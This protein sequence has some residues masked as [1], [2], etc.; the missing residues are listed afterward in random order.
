[1]LVDEIGLSEYIEDDHLVS[2]VNMAI[3]II[4]SKMFPD[5][6]SDFFQLSMAGPVATHV[7]S[8]DQTMFS[9]SDAAPFAFRYS[10]NLKGLT[11]SLD[12][13]KQELSLTEDVRLLHGIMAENTCGQLTHAY[14]GRGMESVQQSLPFYKDQVRYRVFGKDYVFSSAKE[15]GRITATAIKMPK[16]F[17]NSPAP[18]DETDLAQNMLRA[19]TLLSALFF[20]SSIRDNELAT[21]IT[22]LFNSLR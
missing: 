14:M 8:L 3:W 18:S 17:S 11:T 16:L 22:A 6:F 12:I 10:G 1:M 13:V 7:G 19:I 15:Y 5:A 4:Y 9:A 2:L 21:S 20:A